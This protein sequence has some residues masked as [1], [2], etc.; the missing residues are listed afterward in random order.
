M[1]VYTRGNRILAY[2]PLY[3]INHVPVSEPGH[4]HM[5]RLSRQDIDAMAELSSTIYASLGKGQEC[6][7]H[8]HDR[9]YYEQMMNN[10]RMHFVGAFNGRQLIAMS[11]VR[12]V[13]SRKE[14]FEEF[15]TANVSF[16][17]K[18]FQAA[19]L[20]ADSVHPDY[21]GNH[22]NANM[23][24]FRLKYAENMQIRDCLSIIDRKNIWNMRPYFA[25]D[26]VMMGAD[27]DP[28]DGGNIALMHR[29]LD[30]KTV[31]G[32]EAH[33]E[34]PVERYGLLDKLFASGNIAVGYS[35]TNNALQIVP[36]SYYQERNVRSW[37]PAVMSKGR[38]YAD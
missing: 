9:G 20:G 31:Y 26:F 22:I 35:S 28:S 8:K 16:L 13:R 12:I 21:R 17:G 36:C 3:K 32:R 37:N 18:G 2:A 4:Y 10:P 7:I 11:Y 6:F 19:C 33:I 5:R 14:L 25:N 1:Q 15:P 34:I 23:I 29:R 27:I 38:R 30:K 24:H